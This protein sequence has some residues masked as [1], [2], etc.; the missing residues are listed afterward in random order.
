MEPLRVGVVGLGWAGEQHLKSYLWLPNVE[1]VALAG[2]EEPKLHEL[3]QRYGVPNLHRDYEE[4][5][6]RAT[7][8]TQ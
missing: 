5:R 8:S 3:G 7:T 2:L 4:V 1:I 6:S